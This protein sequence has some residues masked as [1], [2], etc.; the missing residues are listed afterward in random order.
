MTKI[1]DTVNWS[2]HEGDF[3]HFTT[4]TRMYQDVQGVPEG[5]T[6]VFCFARFF[7]KV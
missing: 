6:F 5:E 4:E 3:T 2:K 7:K 1:Q